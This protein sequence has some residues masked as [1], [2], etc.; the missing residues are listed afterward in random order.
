MNPELKA[1]WIAALRSGNYKQGRGRLK[2]AGR[3]CCLGVLGDVMGCQFTRHI[4]FKDGIDVGDVGAYHSGFLSKHVG[5]HLNQQSNLV[6]MNDGGK[7][8]DE[9]ADWIE[10]NL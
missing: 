10:A 6:C 2:H 4:V 1:K 3:Y 5:L 7:S 9:I 8:F